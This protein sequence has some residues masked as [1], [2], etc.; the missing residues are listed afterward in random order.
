MFRRTPI[1]VALALILAAFAAACSSDSKS[2]KAPTSAPASPTAVLSAAAVAPRPSPGCSQVAPAPGESAQTLTIGSDARTY[3][4]LV[5]SAATD[6]E[7]LPLIIDLHGLT[8]TA[9]EQAS[10]SGFETLGEQRGAFVLTPQGLG[11]SAAWHPNTL[12][13]NPDIDF[14]TQLIDTSEQQFCIDTARVF[15]GGISLGGIM[16]SAMGC[17]LADRIAAIGLVSGI[18]FPDACQPARGLPVVVFWGK[19]DTVLPYYGGIGYSLTHEGPAPLPPTAPP[20]DT[21]GFPPVETVLAR[22]AAADGC[23]TTPQTTQVSQHVERRTFSGCAEG[24][25]VEFYVISNGGHAWPGTPLE[26]LQ[27]LVP[28]ADLAQA[29]ASTTQE[30]SAT[31][32][33]W[34]F[35]MQHPLVQ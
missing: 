26:V 19:L 20:A 3:R 24:S 4:Q 23:Q 16:T 2:A 9:A 34:D 29:V 33:L 11:T 28:A 7:P 18:R 32:L 1:L 25:A 35:W 21:Q 15:M 17:Q 31:A 14:L 12:T 5:P 8:A 10:V 13:G 6:H 22:W 30:I 27:R